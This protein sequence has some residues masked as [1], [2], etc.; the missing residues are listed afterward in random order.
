[1]KKVGHY[2][3]AVWLQSRGTTLQ[4]ALGRAIAA[5]PAQTLH[6]FDVND[7]E[8]CLVA[9]ANSVAGSVFLHLVVYEQGAGAAVISTLTRARQAN[10]NEEPPPAGREYIISQVFCHVQG[11]HVIWTTHNTPLRDASIYMLFAG[12]LESLIGAQAPT[13]FGLRAILDQAA[14]RR[15]FQRGIEEIDLGLGDFRSTLE[16]LVSGGNLP[17]MGF[18]D[19]LRSL[20]GTTPTRQ[21][22][23]AAAMVEGRLTLRPGRDW[24]HPQVAS[25]LSKVARSVVANHSDEFTILTKDGLRLTRDKMTV[26]RDYRVDG[27]KR[28]LNQPQVRQSLQRIF[29]E[30][31]NAGVIT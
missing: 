4:S 13:Q 19:H 21:E 5:I 8:Q 9:V 2:R 24:S 10:A 12:F 14:Y 7:D 3:R 15:A 17:R 31:Q 18:V 16:R 25:V 30:L 11:N 29:G 26:Q 1:M 27:N 6:A 23:E 20:V 22:L 28:V